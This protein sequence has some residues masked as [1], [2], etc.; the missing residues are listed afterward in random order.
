MINAFLLV[1]FRGPWLWAGTFDSR[2]TAPIS[3]WLVPLLLGIAAGALASRSNTP[4]VRAPWWLGPAV[5]GL[6]TMLVIVSES[7]S[8]AESL[9]PPMRGVLLLAMT[10][11][12]VILL[13]LQNTGV[14]S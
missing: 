10:L 8:P 4:K 6:A 12:G 13:A 7:V 9:Y 2:S 14:I 5:A 11:F 3:V 1:T